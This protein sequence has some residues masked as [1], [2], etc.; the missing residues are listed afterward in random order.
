MRVFDHLV[1]PSSIGRVA[2]HLGLWITLFGIRFYFIAISFNVYSGF[3]VQAM[4]GLS[5]YSTAMIAGAYYVIVEVIA[6]QWRRARYFR[7]V[8][9]L[10]VLLFVFTVVDAVLEKALLMG[11]SACMV[12]LHR[13]QA[14]YEA[15]IRS[16]LPN[17]VLKR[18]LSFGTP[19]T[20]LLNLMVP[21]FLKMAVNAYRATLLSAR[22]A[23]ENLQLELHFLKAQLNPHFLFN[24]M[25]NIYGLVLSDDRERAATLVAGLS[26]LLRYV[27]YE[28]DGDRLPLEKE[29]KLIADYVTL[30]RVRLN[31][32][33]VDVV[34]STDTPDYRVAPLLLMPLFE[35]AFKCCTDR[36]GAYIRGSVC[37]AAGQLELTLANTY[38]A[39]AAQPGRQGIG[40]ENL[41]RRLELY[42][43]GRY[44]Y[45]V[46]QADV[47]RVNLKI[48]L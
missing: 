24:S 31:H 17:I 26:D 10:L 33:L 8:G 45:S 21:L 30:E 44:S 42:Y 11:C 15:M 29:M 27:L 5:L 3:P 14:A 36:P 41:K 46:T 39:H 28:T 38:D 9:I 25:N 20:L 22:L 18:F 37:A 34:Q 19:V 2:L 13:D 7:A 48:Q 1:N 6:G 12:R 47:Y 35:N 4:L 32:V 43:P 16:D 40:L 23:R